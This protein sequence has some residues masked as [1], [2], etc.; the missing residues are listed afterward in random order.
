MADETYQGWTNRETWCVHLWLTNEATLYA[1]AL[2]AAKA[3]DVF[4]PQNVE[5]YARNAFDE[6]QEQTGW[7]LD[8]IN[9]VLIRVNWDEVS[10]ALRE[11]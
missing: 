4:A 5:N 7:T 1:G 11:G 2:A 6:S 3:V 9:C 8:M 10:S